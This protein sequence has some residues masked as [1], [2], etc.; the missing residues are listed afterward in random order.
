MPFQIP[1]NHKFGCVCLVN[2][3]VDRELREPLDLGGGLWAVFGA[4]LELAPHWQNWLGSVKTENFARAGITFLAH[5]A[6]DR[7]EIVDNENKSLE[8]IA[9]FEFLALS[10]CEIF[11]YDDGM[12]LSG[13][14][15]NGHIDIRNVSDIDTHIRPNGVRPSRIISGTI[16]RASNVASGIRLIHSERFQ[17]LRSGFRAW[18]RGIREYYG[19]DRLHQ[20]VRAVESVVKPEIGR[21]ERQFVHRCQIFAGASEQARALFSEIYRMRSQ[22]EHMNDLESVL[23]VYP[24]ENREII[25]L[26]RAYQAQIL[27]SHV[28]EQILTSPELLAIFDA[29]DKIDEFWTERRMDEQEATWGRAIDLEKE[30]E[31]RFL[32]GIEV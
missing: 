31:A 6:S 17:R 15:N 12:I 21:T 20:F 2:A 23:A 30:A 11:H 19:Q 29:D 22:T 1:L 25:A 4:P 13:A 9:F 18:H 32:D 5:R 26:R 28:F 27:A 14:N 10:I 16:R 7:P 24:M 3:A 8:E